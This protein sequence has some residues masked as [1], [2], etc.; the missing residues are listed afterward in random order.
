MSTETHKITN[1]AKTLPMVSQYRERKLIGGFDTGVLVAAAN[2]EEDKICGFP[3]SNNSQ[4]GSPSHRMRFILAKEETHVKTLG[5]LPTRLLLFCLQQTFHLI[6]F[7]SAVGP[8]P[9][10]PPQSKEHTLCPQ[11]SKIAT[12]KSVC[13]WTRIGRRHLP[14]HRQNK[15]NTDDAGACPNGL[16]GSL[17][18]AKIPCPGVGEEESGEF[19]RR[20]LV[21]GGGEVV[22]DMRCVAPCPCKKRDTSAQKKTSSR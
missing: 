11:F 12:P 13:T 22:V 18:S 19:I 16:S 17:L 5:R 8:H 14:P 20:S 6:L 10:P 1:T 3:T 9:Q 21:D 4:F 15:G 7:L 2:D